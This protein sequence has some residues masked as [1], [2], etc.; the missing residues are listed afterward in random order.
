MKESPNNQKSFTATQGK[1]KVIKLRSS[2]SIMDGNSVQTPFIAPYRI[3]KNKDGHREP[4]TSVQYTWESIENGVVVKR[5][6]EVSG[7]GRLGV[8]TLKDKE[9]LRAL[10]D[11]YIWSKIDKGV[12]RLETD[13]SKV[14]EQDLMVDFIS[15]E[16][17]AKAMGYKSISGQQRTFIKESIERLVATTIFNRYSGGL[18]D[19]ISKRYIT[20]RN[21]SY[22]YLDEMDNYIEYDC[23]SCSCKN[24][25]NKNIKHCIN[26]DNQKRDVTK[27]KLSTFVYLNIANN[28][29]LYYD[30]DNANLIRN[31]I[32]KNIYL[33]SR[34]WIGNGYVA[35]ANI[36]KY[37]DRIPM[38]A[39]QEKHRKQALKEGLD[40]LNTYDFVE[41]TIDKKDIVTVKHLDKK[42]T[43][44]G[45]IKTIE[46]DKKPTDL[47]YYKDRYTTFMK[48]RERL[49]EIGFT[50]LEFNNVIEANIQKIEYF[51]ALMR[52]V[53]MRCNYDTNINPY[54]YF[55]NCWNSKKEIEDKYYTKLS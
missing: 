18:Y 19:P 3:P 37:M 7:H 16:N 8:P 27:I 11:I 22:K 25:C 17:I 44:K 35:V 47:S 39:K 55:I 21:V 46:N 30:R 26:E 14:T 38:N 9:V 53:D 24:I 1:Q 32:A 41:A 33:I 23:G 28:Y 4:L 52:Y 2:E 10:Q 29:R 5:G 51:K 6:L 43:N 36:K 45:N 12:L 48:L 42:P 31:L 15:I 13:L 20:D 49:L 34:K 50:E 54:D 40:I